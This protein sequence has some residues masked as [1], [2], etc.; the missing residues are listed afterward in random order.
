[1]ALV[2]LGALVLAGCS[3]TE[4]VD[5]LLQEHGLA[6]MDGRQIVEH[7]EATGQ[8]RPLPYGASVRETEV[9][10]SE[11]EHEVAVP[12]PSGQHYVSI[13]PY[14]DV[15]HDCYYHSLATC[16]GELVE[17]PVEVTITS[18]D[19]EVLV[20]EQAVTHPNGFVGFWVP[21][22]TAGTIEVTYEGM[23]GAVP[24]TTEDGDPTC[25]TT[26]QVT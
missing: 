21:S 17:Q 4:E 6:G 9:L 10:L 24:F 5:P 16:Q 2:A 25:I 11:G 19:G 14:V 8:A 3:P 12:L 18:D 1:M 26:L 23:A 13:A 7:L 20:Q 15:T 22:G